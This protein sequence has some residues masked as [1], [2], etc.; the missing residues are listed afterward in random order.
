MMPNVFGTPQRVLAPRVPFRHAIRPLRPTSVCAVRTDAY[1]DAMTTTCIAPIQIRVAPQ[2]EE[3]TA[4]RSII[5][6]GQTTERRI[7]RNPAR[8]AQSM[9][10][11]GW[12]PRLLS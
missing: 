4:V 10:F 2:R 11:T 12:G 9:L 6:P 1:R 7:A 5:A 3:R 8:P